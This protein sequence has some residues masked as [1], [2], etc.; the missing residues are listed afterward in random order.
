LIIFCFA[1]VLAA[2][3]AFAAIVAGGSFAL[4]RQP[5]SDASD[6][7]AQEQAPANP[8][9]AAPKAGNRATFSGLVTD[10]YCGARHRRYRNLAPI[11]CAAACIRGG[12]TY[13][14]VNGDHRYKLSGS[15]KALTR[16]LATRANV[17]GTLQGDTILVD[18]A[19]PLF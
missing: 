5:E 17:T 19:A 18:S 16:L 3:L 15:E 4:V 9:P 13:V 11:E 6:S 2:A 7:R 8:N 12:A 1:A 10:S 14:L